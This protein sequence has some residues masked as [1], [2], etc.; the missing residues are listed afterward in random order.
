MKEKKIPKYIIE[1]VEISSDRENSD[2][3][4]YSEEEMSFLREQFLLFFFFFF[5]WDNFDNV[6]F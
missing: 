1:D 4:N 5:L 3:K 6:Y 2:D